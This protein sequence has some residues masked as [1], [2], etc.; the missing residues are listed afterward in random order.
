M[1]N[2]HVCTALALLVC[3]VMIAA[4]S[5]DPSSEVSLPDPE[6]PE[7]K[8]VRRQIAE[9]W[10]T[11]IDAA[12]RKDLAGVME[13]YAEDILYSVPGAPVIEGLTALIEMEAAALKQADVVTAKHEMHAMQLLDNIVYEIGTIEG[14]VQPRGEEARIVT[15]HFMAQWR[16]RDDGAWKMTALVGKPA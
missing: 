14:P 12:Q 13:I 7:T 9:A 10:R 8:E 4:C 15:F 2:S 1:R 6:D 3:A 16:R 5:I 11:H